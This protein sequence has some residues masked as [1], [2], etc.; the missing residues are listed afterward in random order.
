MSYTIQFTKPAQ[1]DLREIGDCLH[2]AAGNSVAEWWIE[3]IIAK[4]ETLRFMPTR[5]RERVELMAGVRAVSVGNYLVFY[6][7]IEDTV[8]ILR[9]VHSSRNI[10]AKLFSNFR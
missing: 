3:E 2:R 4:T 9:V 6:C 7:V 10:T 1:R 5:Q 8:S